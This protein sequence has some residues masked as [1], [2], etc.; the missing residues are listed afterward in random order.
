[1]TSTEQLKE[2]IDNLCDDLFN[3]GFDSNGDFPTEHRR[4]GVIIEESKQAILTAFNNHVDRCAPEKN[5][6]PYNR[7]RATL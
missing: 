1:M 3:A 2:E 4:K 6:P 7:E 5:A